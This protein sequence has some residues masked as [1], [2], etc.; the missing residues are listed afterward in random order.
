[1]SYVDALLLATLLPGEPAFA[2]KRE[3]AGQTFAGP[4]LRRLGPSFVELYDGSRSL[5]DIGSPIA[6]ARHGRNIVFYPE[7]TFTRPNDFLLI[8]SR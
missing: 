7:G 1:L 6:V 5:A 2:A 8:S 3:F 4:L